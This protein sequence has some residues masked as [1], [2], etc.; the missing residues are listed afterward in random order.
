MPLGW[1]SVIQAK[2]RSILASAVDDQM[3]PSEPVS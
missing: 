1:L 3:I 2:I